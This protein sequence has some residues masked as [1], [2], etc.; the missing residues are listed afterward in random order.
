VPAT[1]PHSFTDATGVEWDIEGYSRTCGPSYVDCRSKDGKALTVRPLAYLAP[2][3]LSLP[4]DAAPPERAATPNEKKTAESLAE[5]MLG[6][7]AK[8]PRIP[9][10]QKDAKVIA[11]PTT[12]PV[13][14]F[15]TAL[16]VPL[17]S[18]ENPRQG[19]PGD[20]AAPGRARDAA[21]EARDAIARAYAAE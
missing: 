20:T 19:A 15:T 5:R 3:G 21:A 1:G 11:L 9:P 4:P 18:P 6:R 7:P 16:H 14:A 2:A 12:D 13:R 10:A 8:T 17:A